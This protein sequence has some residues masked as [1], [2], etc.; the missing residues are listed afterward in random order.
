[1][2]NSFCLS[3]MQ[4][5]KPVNTYQLMILPPCVEDFI[6]SGHLSR[7]INDVVETM[8]VIDIETRYSYLG[9][10]SYHPYLLSKLLFYEYSTGMRSGRKKQTPKQSI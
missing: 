2:V 9:Q 4:K 8:N 1:M 6:P 3:S 7:V 5:F 10:K